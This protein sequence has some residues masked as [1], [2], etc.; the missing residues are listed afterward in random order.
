MDQELDVSEQIATLSEQW[1]AL[2]TANSGKT[3][4]LREAN[5]QQQFN[6][7]VKDMDFWLGEVEAQ[8]SS[9]EVGRDL[10][11][12][13]SLLKKHQ[14][15]EADVTAHEVSLSSLALPWRLL[16]GISLFPSQERVRDLNAQAEKFVREQHFDSDSI[17][18][19]QRSINDRYAR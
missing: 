12:V 11:G 4:K 15:V 1:S 13:H 7:A 5:Q 17:Q 14:L 8:L 16:V 19:K 9:G 3:Q 6:E 18:E 2:L 10:A